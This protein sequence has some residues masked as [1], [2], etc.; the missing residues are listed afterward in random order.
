MFIQSFNVNS[1]NVQFLFIQFIH[2]F[3]K[4]A[5]RGAAV[6]RPTDVE[7]AINYV[8]C[9]GLVSKTYIKSPL[10]HTIQDIT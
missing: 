6:R 4:M 7:P 8:Q 5:N 9:D 2:P 10:I 3:S 1:F